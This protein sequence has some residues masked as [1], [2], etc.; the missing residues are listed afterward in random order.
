MKI[1]IFV[2]L[3]IALKN[4]SINQCSL[5]TIILTLF[6]SDHNQYHRNYFETTLPVI[7]KSRASV[8]NVITKYFIVWNIVMQATENHNRYT[9]TLY[10]KTPITGKHTPTPRRKGNRLGCSDAYCS[11]SG[12]VQKRCCEI[13]KNV[14]ICTKQVF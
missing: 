5:H 13:P 12:H 14:T 10:S 6:L 3:W 4:S 2:R 7:T 11:L 8:A 9:Y 1:Y